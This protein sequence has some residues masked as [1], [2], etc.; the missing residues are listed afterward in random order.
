VLALQVDTYAFSFPDE[1][2]QRQR[3]LLPLLDLINHGGE[4][5]NSAIVEAEGGPASLYFVVAVR[6]IRRGLHA[7][8]WMLDNLFCPG[9]C[10]MHSNLPAILPCCAG[11]ERR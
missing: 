7:V 3:R 4:L 2:G 6:D 5:A 9:I 10:L 11:R 1:A 8:R